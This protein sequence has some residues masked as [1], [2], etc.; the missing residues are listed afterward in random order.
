MS[1]LISKD[2][3]VAGEGGAARPEVGDKRQ[4][5]AKARHQGEISPICALSPSPGWPQISHIAEDGL[6]LLSLLTPTPN[7]FINFL[8]GLSHLR[9]P[10]LGVTQG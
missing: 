3:S 7:R 10:D 5:T 6:E 2:N 1:K 9:T 8:L 4:S